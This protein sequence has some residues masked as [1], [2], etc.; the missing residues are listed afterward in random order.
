MK[1]PNLPV[2]L[3]AVLCS[4]L[5]IGQTMPPIQLTQAGLSVESVEGFSNQVVVG[6]PFAAAEE[7]HSLQVLGDGTRIEKT[8]TNHLYR[9]SQGR[10]RIERTGGN[11]TI[12]DPIAGFTAELNPVAKTV[13]KTYLNSGET[14]DL[15]AART[16][17][18]R[19]KLEADRRALQADPPS[20]EADRL[21]KEISEYEKQLAE[22]GSRIQAVFSPTPVDS[23]STTLPG[24]YL[25]RP[26][27]LTPNLPYMNGPLNVP[28]KVPRTKVFYF[29]ADHQVSNIDP[30]NNWSLE[31]LPVQTIN[32]VQAQGTRT[33]ETIPLGKIGN[34]RPIA[35]VNERWSSSDLQM[36]IK[37]T[38]SDP[39]FGDTT[40]QLTNIVQAPPD[41]S[42]FQIPSDYNATSPSLPVVNT[43]LRK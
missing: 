6:K 26:G 2:L 4:G 43:P 8:E 41:P 13:N 27:G 9:D 25:F 30:G 31:N 23:T 19:T 15:N 33:T 37:S 7:R 20:P 5:A 36:L 21:K 29:S 12:F 18:L 32:G 34:D 35:I 24:T 17:V 28:R 40:Y 3:A 16:T 10:T 42:L 11:V 39:R 1:R 22:L 38:S 14:R